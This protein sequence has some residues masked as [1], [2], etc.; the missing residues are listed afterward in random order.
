MQFRKNIQEI[1]QNYWMIILLKGVASGKLN[2]RFAFSVVGKSSNKLFSQMVMKEGD[3]SHGIPIR[4][5]SLKEIQA[6]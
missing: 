1:L 4:K 6:A 2:H 5:K 3:E